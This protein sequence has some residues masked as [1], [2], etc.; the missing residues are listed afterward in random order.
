MENKRQIPESS[1]WT[2]VEPTHRKRDPPRNVP[3][4]GVNN[5]QQ[6]PRRR[7]A[8]APQTP[9]RSDQPIRQQHTPRLIDHTDDNAEALWRAHQPAVD[10][11]RI[12][13]DLILKDKSDNSGQY[14]ETMA[15]QHGTYIW[16]EHNK[17]SGGSRTFGIWGEKAA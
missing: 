16:S 14:H 6:P 8:P 7:N 15:R 1:G 2:V 13:D 5:N 12:P 10:D 11:V 9:D 17:G 4:P 3:K